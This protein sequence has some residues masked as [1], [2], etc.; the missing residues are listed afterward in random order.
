M[1]GL[2][3]Q[4]YIFDELLKTQNRLNLKKKIGQQMHTRIK[5]KIKTIMVCS[6]R[7]A[8]SH[9]RT[10]QAH[11]AVTA[12]QITALQTKHPHSLQASQAS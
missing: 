10:I 9:S 5:E 8:L 2:L 6:A 7:V 1:I 12:N 4:F 11:L 3:T